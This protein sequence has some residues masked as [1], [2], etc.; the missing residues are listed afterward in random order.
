[1]KF[2]DDDDCQAVRSWVVEMGFKNLDKK[3]KKDPTVQIL[4]F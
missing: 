4:G 2:V 1:M 3:T